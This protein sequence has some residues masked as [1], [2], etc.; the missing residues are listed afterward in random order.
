[1]VINGD[2][3]DCVR[4]A[5]PVDYNMIHIRRITQRAASRQL[6]NKGLAVPMH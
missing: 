5:L 3:Q 2:R 6:R 4:H 1:M